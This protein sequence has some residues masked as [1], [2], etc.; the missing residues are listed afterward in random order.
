MVLYKKFIVN[1]KAL[2]NE[3]EGLIRLAFMAKP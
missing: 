1:E 3:S 2:R